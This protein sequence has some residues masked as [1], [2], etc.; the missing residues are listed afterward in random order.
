MKL[1]IITSLILFLVGA[2]QTN[3]KLKRGIIINRYINGQILC[4]VPYYLTDQLDTVVHGTVVYYYPNGVIEDSFF[5]VQD[6][7]KKVSIFDWI[8]WVP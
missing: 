6:K 7:K 3:D 8:Q 1:I 4:K 5:V 2:C